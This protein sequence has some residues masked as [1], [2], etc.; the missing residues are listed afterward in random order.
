MT[1]RLRLYEHERAHTSSCTCTL[2]YT[3]FVLVDD[4]VV[5]GGVSPNCIITKLP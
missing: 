5:V 2:F 3:R 4:F 1:H